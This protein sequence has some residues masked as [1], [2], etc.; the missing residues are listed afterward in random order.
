MPITLN[1]THSLSNQTT[2]QSQAAAHTSHHIRHESM[3]NP[4]VPR[5]L[6]DS[7]SSTSTPDKQHPVCTMRLN[8]RENKA[9]TYE[10]SNSNKKFCKNFSDLVANDCE[11]V[12]FPDPIAYVANLAN[13][14]G[15]VL[16]YENNNGNSGWITSTG[17]TN[18][19]IANCLSDSYYNAVGDL[20]QNSH[21][22]GK[23]LGIAAAGL[24]GGAMLAFVAY[25]MLCRRSRPSDTE[26]QQSSNNIEL[27]TTRAPQ[28]TGS[29]NSMEEFYPN[30]R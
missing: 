17:D 29:F 18:S 14:N 10:V 16:V 4:V 5:N 8:E 3:S 12:G 25:H 26:G 23:Y 13:P 6:G 30:G 11:G 22:T 24:F 27:Q 28:R 15:T 20:K 1:T 2:D 19:V 9:A 7:V 21:N